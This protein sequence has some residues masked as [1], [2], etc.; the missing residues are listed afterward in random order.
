MISSNAL[1]GEDEI[2]EEEKYEHFSFKAPDRRLDI[3][4]STGGNK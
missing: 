2:S 4:S 3:I 1:Y